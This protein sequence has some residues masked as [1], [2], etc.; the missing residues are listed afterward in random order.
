M[1]R[2]R[3]TRPSDGGDR[4]FEVAVTSDADLIEQFFDRE[5]GELELGELIQRVAKSPQAWRRIAE[6]Q[7]LVDQLAEPVSSPDLTESILRRLER[8]P[9]SLLQPVSEPQRWLRFRS[10][11]AASILLALMVGIWMQSWS[12]Q[13]PGAITS[14]QPIS[15]SIDQDVEAIRS[16]TSE[17]PTLL[18]LLPRADLRVAPSLRRARPIGDPVQL[19][20]RWDEPRWRLPG[21]QIEI[22]TLP[23][24]VDGLQPDHGG[25]QGGAD[26]HLT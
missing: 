6:T 2:S 9:E 8:D 24:G 26:L 21:I 19:Y 12:P 14:T 23:D 7:D 18:D 15:D 22:Q 5:A 25:D 20:Q 10:M 3:P 11:A 1:N 4:E 13:H 17:I 16:L